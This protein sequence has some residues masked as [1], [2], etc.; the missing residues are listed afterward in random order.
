LS[1]STKNTDLI[2]DSIPKPISTGASA[3]IMRKNK[4]GFWL[5]LVDNPFA[6]LFF[7]D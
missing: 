1:L 7:A 2:S 4:E 5:W 3:H 6:A